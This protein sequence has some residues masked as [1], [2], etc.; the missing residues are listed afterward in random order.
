MSG[1]S[2]NHFKN[3]SRAFLASLLN[4]S[5][6]S[7]RA[8]LT[9][10]A[11]SSGVEGPRLLCATTVR[12]KRRQKAKSQSVR[13][14]TVI[15]TLSSLCVLGYRGPVNLRTRILRRIARY[16]LVAQHQEDEF[17]V[18]VSRSFLEG[19]GIGSQRRVG[20]EQGHR[21]LD[22]AVVREAGSLSGK[23]PP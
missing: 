16:R 12:R 4:G 2:I 15:S 21:C 7:K 14:E 22:V 23:H 8:D 18:A 13:I 5:V 3:H 11:R 10:V 17:L 20:R 9:A 19:F 1:A 6:S